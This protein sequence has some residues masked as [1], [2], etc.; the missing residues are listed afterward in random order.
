MES[1][2]DRQE[3]IQKRVQKIRGFY[4]SLIT[5]FLVNVLLLIINL[6]FDRHNLWF[7]WVA[8]IWGIVIIVQAI[9]TFSLQDSFLGDAWEKKKIEELEAREKKK[10]HQGE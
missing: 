8:G 5:F 1:D 9:K 7:Y 2:K 10:P 4:S 6:L 3:R